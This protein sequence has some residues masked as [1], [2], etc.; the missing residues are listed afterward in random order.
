MTMALGGASTAAAAEGKSIAIVGLAT[1]GLGEDVREQFETLVEE[2]LRKLGY[3]V[4]TRAA[5]LDVITTRELPEG[6]TF[7]PCARA[8]GGALAAGR[9]LDAR[10]SAEGQSYSFVL[11]MVDAPS[12]QAV[13]QVVGSC[14][15]CTVAE[16]LTRVSD[17]IQVLEGGALAVP[18]GVERQA[19]RR[20]GS[21]LPPILLSIAGAAATGGGALLVTRTAHDEAG[22]A[23]IGAGATA[24]LTGLVWL[25]VGE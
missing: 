15:V 24:L 23:T 17:S 8:V 21:R 10:I 6:C 16:A 5:A 3:H 12:G 2:G 18:P 11:S 1:E 9:L 22:W 20:R 4:V 19:A 25:F 13:A 14:P 7:G